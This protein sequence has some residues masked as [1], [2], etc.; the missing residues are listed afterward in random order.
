MTKPLFTSFI[1]CFLT[2]FV[3]GQQ[4]QR[5]DPFYYQVSGLVYV[6]EFDALTRTKTTNT[7]IPKEPLKFKIVVKEVDATDNSTFY[8]IKFLQIDDETGTASIASLKASTTFV[9]STDND[10]FFW[11]RKDKLDDCMTEGFITKS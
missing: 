3:F 5:E 9:N 7:K 6:N 2:N 11:I 10:K 8:V 1:L 4:S